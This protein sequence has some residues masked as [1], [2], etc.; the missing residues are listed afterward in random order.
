MEVCSPKKKCFSIK[1]AAHLGQK[2]NSTAFMQSAQ[3]LLC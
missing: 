2:A 1:K 3:D